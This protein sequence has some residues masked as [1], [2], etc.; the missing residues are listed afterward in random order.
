M[1]LKNIKN[2]FFIGIGGIGMSA[3]AR[4][5]LQQGMIVQGYDKTPS[6]VTDALQQEGASITFKDETEQAAADAGLVVYTPAIPQD[7]QLLRYY[8]EHN[9]PLLKRS[10][11]LQ[12]VLEHYATIAI[13]GTH[14]K[15]TIST[16]TAYLLREAGKGCN[17]FLGGIANN[18]V[19][20]YWY[21][22]EPVA[23]VEAD[24]YDRSFLK[25]A[26]DM[27]VLSAMDADHLDIYGT[28]EALEAAFLAFTQKIKPG[29]ILLYKH[30]LHQVAA[31][32]GATHISYSL[33]NPAADAH[34]RNIR[35]EKGG[36]HFDVAGPGWLLAD[37]YLPIGG[38][39]NVE[40]TVAA[41]TLAKLQGADGAAIRAALKN[42]MGVKRR[43]EYVLKNEKHVFI[44]DYAHHPEEIAALIHSAK[45]LFPDRKCVIAFQPHLY[46]RTRDLAEGFARSLDLADEV[47]LLEIYPARE[48][49]LPGISAQTIAEKMANPVHTILSKDGLLW[50]VQAANP[51]LFITAGAGDIDRLVPAIKEILEEK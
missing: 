12:L 51:Q 13:A 42:F 4:Y 46:S 29:G 16:L 14:G 24:E 5:C 2:I 23:V 27:A 48:L 6:P 17:A 26:P 31:M 9:F 18:Y 38:M 44:D 15:T 30:G 50:Y 33:Q 39:H 19:T 25:L 35:Q 47:I 3:L 36:Y 28:A 37:L 8:R 40:N 10:D 49:P 1:N 41:V 21:S 20:N 32:G 34:A 43:F 45:K 11:L 22:P 7:N